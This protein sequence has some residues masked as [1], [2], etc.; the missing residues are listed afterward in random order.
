M[1]VARRHVSWLASQAMSP[2]R[3]LPS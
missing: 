2:P 1:A 3:L